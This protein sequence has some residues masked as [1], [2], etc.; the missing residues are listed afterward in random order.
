MW[1]GFVSTWQTEGIVGLYRGVG[2]AIIG[3]SNGAIQFMAYEQLKQWRS[4]AYLRRTSSDARF[5]EQQ[6]DN[7]KLPN[8]EY[9]LISGAAKLFAILLTYPYQVIR[10]R[11]Q[12]LATSHLY[13]STWDCAR[14]TFRDEG[15]RGMYRGLATNIVRILPGTCV[16]FVAYENVSWML[17]TAAARRSS[18]STSEQH[19]V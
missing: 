2:L 13:R 12:S 15:L 7:V 11:V 14:I 6:L 16:T 5:S 8:V 18:T 1:H 17:R 19:T 9:T 3:V 10:S 4:S